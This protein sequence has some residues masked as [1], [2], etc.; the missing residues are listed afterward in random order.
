MGLE[1]LFERI[2]RRFANPLSLECMPQSRDEL[3]DLHRP[4]LEAYNHLFDVLPS[5]NLEEIDAFEAPRDIDETNTY[6]IYRSLRRESV[7]KGQQRDN[8]H[9]DD[10]LLS[11]FPSLSPLSLTPNEQSPELYS[12]AEVIL[13]FGRLPPRVSFEQLL[14]A[15]LLVQHCA[16]S[17]MRLLVQYSPM[18]DPVFVEMLLPGELLF[19]VCR[20][21]YPPLANIDMRAER[22]LQLQYLSGIWSIRSQGLAPTLDVFRGNTVSFATLLHAIYPTRR[23]TTMFLEADAR[24]N[25]PQQY[26]ACFTPSALEETV[27][28]NLA[29]DALYLDNL[30]SDIGA[31]L[32]PDVAT[33][34]AFLSSASD[35]N[36]VAWTLYTGHKRQELTFLSDSELLS[37]ALVVASSREELVAKVGD[38]LAGV[39]RHLYFV[40]DGSK[41]SNDEDP[42]T[43]DDVQKALSIGN[44]QSNTCMSVPTLVEL[45]QQENLEHYRGLFDPSTDGVFDYQE[46]EEIS[47]L[48]VRYAGKVG[49]NVF[50][51]RVLASSLMT[52]YDKI[53][54]VDEVFHNLSQDDKA[55]CQ[56]I[57]E[58]LFRAGMYM[59]GWKGPGTPYP[60]KEQQ[61]FCTISP[62]VE[63]VYSSD[64]AMA[65][66]LMESSRPLAFLFSSMSVY[67]IE[68]TGTLQE[69]NSSL[70]NLVAGLL[71]GETCMRILSNE[72][73]ATSTFFLKRFF[74]TIPSGFDVQELEKTVF[75]AEEFERA[76]RG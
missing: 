39:G 38:I 47:N 62:E 60:L 30:L 74:D 10:E 75:S 11:R 16:R 42:V 64:F 37:R 6:T 61:T 5:L 53:F 66:R 18:V 44:A 70:F 12:A 34:T 76:R 32:P 71:G 9:I 40:V 48:L 52:F 21:R 33:D 15:F 68:T 58:S 13:T 65:H 67:T 49:V 25:F 59:R 36:N 46:A 23:P 29:D 50:Q 26:F 73:I 41:C 14:A 7:E 69:K 24:N 1:S 17:V 57:L 51:A 8:S 19:C 72:L 28:T 2:E 22:F 55:I 45:L 63:V 20:R 54:G 4:W 27:R 35:Y 43:L 3:F 31:V 56:R